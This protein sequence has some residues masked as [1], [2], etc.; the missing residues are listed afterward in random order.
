MQSYNIFGAT[1]ITTTLHY[2]TLHY[3]TLHYT[4]LHYTTL[5]YTS[6]QKFSWYA[7]TALP[8]YTGQPT[9]A[10]RTDADGKGHADHPQIRWCR[11]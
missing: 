1:H 6:L 8:T 5:H 10:A 11:A 2:T 9:E 3:T 7:H 4:T